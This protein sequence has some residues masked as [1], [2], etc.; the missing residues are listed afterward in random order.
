MPIV[1]KCQKRL[2][3]CTN[4]FSRP[5]LFKKT[6]GFRHGISSPFW[7]LSSFYILGMKIAAKNRQFGT[8]ARYKRLPVKR[9]RA[10]RFQKTITVNR[11]VPEVYSFGR[12]LENLP[13][14]IKHLKSV[15]GNGGNISHWIA[16]IG[17]TTFEWDAETIEVRP[18]EMISW[19]SLPAA[20]VDHAGSISFRPTAGNHG[21]VVKV[22]LKYALPEGRAKS[23]VLNVFDK[24][25]KPVIDDDLSCFKSLLETGE[26]STKES[27]NNWG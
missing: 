2:A 6:K 5:C 11:L 3:I 20:E 19:Q 25:A 9:S 27:W 22:S 18:Y 7:R 26:N 1:Q 21:T 10:I 17:G 8:R 15:Y 16:T 12:R 13:R 14:F 24:G 4:H 23:K